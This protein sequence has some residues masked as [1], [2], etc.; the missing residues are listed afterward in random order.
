MAR[1]SVPNKN[2]KSY[3]ISGI[4]RVDQGTRP[5]TS[6]IVLCD[7]WWLVKMFCLGNAQKSLINR[8]PPHIC[9]KN[10]NRN[11]PANPPLI[12]GNFEFIRVAMLHVKKNKTSVSNPVSFTIYFRLQII[13]GTKWNVQLQISTQA[14]TCLH[15]HHHHPNFLGQAPICSSSTRT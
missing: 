5:Q 1:P 12:F 11:V 9:V 3:T 2:H 10:W 13:F 7:T 4:C 15:H 8:N 6:Q 14:D